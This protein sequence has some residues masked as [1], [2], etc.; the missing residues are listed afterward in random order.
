[1]P[2]RRVAWPVKILQSGRNMIYYGEQKGGN[3]MTEETMLML[4]PVAALAIFAV[5][6]LFTVGFS[7]SG[8][9]LGK[10]NKTLRKMMEE[11]SA[12]K[13]DNASPEPKE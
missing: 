7:K 6:L 2:E 5:A 12:E 9:V 1:M 3:S 8:K 13:E 4:V 11:D 10:H